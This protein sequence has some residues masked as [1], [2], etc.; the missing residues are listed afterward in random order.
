MHFYF[1]ETAP[2]SGKNNLSLSTFSPLPWYNIPYYPFSI[3]FD[4][5][6]DN[7]R[8]VEIEYRDSKEV[9]LF[10]GVKTTSDEVRAIY[11][12]FDIIPSKLV[13]GIVTPYGVR[14]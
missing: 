14:R 9:K 12:C 4:E 5:T 7:I 3:S 2:F 1:R 13:T 8:D 10:K 6:K 11:P